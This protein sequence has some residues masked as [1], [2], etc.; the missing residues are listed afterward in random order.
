[1]KIEKNEDSKWFV[2]ESVTNL[3]DED[4]TTYPPY[5]SGINF[6]NSIQMAKDFSVF[7]M[8]VCHQHKNCRKVTHI[9]IGI[10]R[11][12]ASLVF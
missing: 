11:E 9:M 3:L 10:S 5:C 12:F 4:D 7:R 2:D 1:M 6:F 8:A